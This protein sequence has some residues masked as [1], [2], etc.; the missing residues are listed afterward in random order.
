MEIEHIFRDG[1]VA[2]ENT[3][4]LFFEFPRAILQIFHSLFHFEPLTSDDQVVPY[5]V[6]TNFS[7][8]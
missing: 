1:C 6:S 4:R 3:F 5:L 2:D 7:E 8:K